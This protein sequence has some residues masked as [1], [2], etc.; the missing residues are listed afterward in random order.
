MFKG[1]YLGFDEEW[2]TWNSAFFV[3]DKSNCLFLE[4][5]PVGQRCKTHH[6]WTRAMVGISEIQ[7]VEKVMYTF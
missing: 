7:T 6:V 2:G 4:L 5:A 1:Q 3:E